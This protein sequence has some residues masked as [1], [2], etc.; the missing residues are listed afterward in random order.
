VGVVLKGKEQLTGKNA[1]VR[2]LTTIRNACQSGTRKRGSMDKTLTY[3]LERFLSKSSDRSDCTPV[4]LDRRTN[5]IHA[6]AQDHNSMVVES[7][8]ALAGI[9]SDIQIVG[10]G[11]ELGGHGINCQNVSTGP[12]TKRTVDLLCLTKGVMPASTRIRRT[13]SSFESQNLAS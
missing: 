7:K 13:A 12:R 10:V 1:L 11:G 8:I 5:T 9:V 3:R 2:T 4:E 6:G